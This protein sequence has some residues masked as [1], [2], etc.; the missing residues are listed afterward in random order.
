MNSFYTD[1]PEAIAIVQRAFP[2]YRHAPSRLSVKLFHPVKPISYWNGGTKDYWAMAT[3]DGQSASGAAKENGS[4]FGP[5]AE[6]I[7]ELPQGMALVRYTT[8][9]FCCAVIF[10]NSENLSKMLPA[11]TALD[12]DEAVVLVCSSGLKSAYR[13]EKIRDNGLTPERAETA[14][15]NLINKRL[16][17]KNGAVTTEGRNAANAQPNKQAILWAKLY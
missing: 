3:L 7:K 4:G 17:L 12:N 9:N 10:V 11:P 16:L 5:I 15:Q 13:K 1:A 6:E 8:G 2:E 14:K